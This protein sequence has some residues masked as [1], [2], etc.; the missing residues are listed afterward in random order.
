MHRNIVS[1]QKLRNVG[2]TVNDVGGTRKQVPLSPS[3]LANR[4]Q[5]KRSYTNSNLPT[6]NL[7]TTVKN[8]IHTVS[9]SS[10][11]SYIASGGVDGSVRVWNARTGALEI[12]LKG[13]VGSV[14]SVSFSPDSRRIVSG[15]DDGMVRIWNLATKKQERAINASP[16]IVP[17][18]SIQVYQGNDRTDTSQY[19]NI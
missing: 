16:H 12:E 10:N 19:L 3:T 17:V 8:G 4:R 6:S 11:G 18:A 15:G 1:Y 2:K 5:L 9:Y 13:H 14:R 7:K